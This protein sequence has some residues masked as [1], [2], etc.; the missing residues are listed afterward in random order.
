MHREYVIDWNRLRSED[1]KRTSFELLC[2]QVARL[3]KP[4]SG[5]EFIPN[6]NPDGG[7]DCYWRLKNS[8]IHAWQ[9]KFF[10]R[11]EKS[12]WDQID[13]SVKNAIKNYPKLTKYT[14]CVPLN[15]PNSSQ[16]SARQ[17]WERYKKKW[18]KLKSGVEYIFHGHDEFVNLLSNDTY[19]GKLKYFFG[20]I[21]FTQTWLNDQMD[22]LKEAI[23]LRYSEEYNIDLPIIEK[24]NALCKTNEFI[25]NMHTYSDNLDKS[26]KVVNCLS[27]NIDIDFKIYDEKIMN[28]INKLKSVNTQIEHDVKIKDLINECDLIANDLEL[29]EKRIESYDMF[30]SYEPHM[31]DNNRNNQLLHQAQNKLRNARSLL[32]QNLHRLQI[33]LEE[34]ICADTRQ[35][36]V[37]GDAG[38]G[39]T[40]LFFDVLQKRLEK[41]HPTILLLGQWF[42]NDPLD[43]IPKLLRLDCNID[44]FLGAFNSHAEATGHRALLLIDA[45]NESPNDNIWKNHLKRLSEI[46]SRYKSI[47]FAISVRSGY[48]KKYDDIIP[49]RCMCVEHKGFQ[50]NPKKYVDIFFTKNGL[51]APMMPFLRQEFSTPQFLYLL[52]RT[53][54]EKQIRNTSYDSLDI[55]S[56]YILYIK[57]INKK[58]CKSDKLD[59]DENSNIVENGINELARL[60]ISQSTLELDYD[61]AYNCLMGV[62]YSEGNSKSLLYNLIQEGILLKDDERNKIRFVYERLAE[63]LITREY[64]NEFDHSTIKKSFHNGGKLF[65]F[66]SGDNF[67]DNNSGI[68]DAILIQLPDKFGIELV[69]II[70]DVLNNPKMVIAILGSLPL[71]KSNNITTKTIESLQEIIL[72]NGN[73]DEYFKALLTL[74]IKE[75]Q[76]INANYLHRK[77]LSMEISERDLLWSTFIHRQYSNEG[78]VFNY[79]NWAQNVKYDLNSRE[80]VSLAATTMCW[81]LTS[82]HKIIRDNVI[83]A[84]IELMHN[85]AEEWLMI[86]KKFKNCNDPYV[87]ANLYAVTYAIVLTNTTSESQIEKI[88]LYVYSEIFAA[89]NPPHSIFIQDYARRI[90]NYANIVIPNLSI[91]S[92]NVE[93]PYK[94]AILKFPKINKIELLISRISE[95]GYDNC[96]VKDQGLLSLGHS[97]NEMSDFVRYTLGSNSNAFPWYNIK[98]KQGKSI[99]DDVQ[100]IFKKSP[101]LSELLY[102]YIKDLKCQK[103][104]FMYNSTKKN[105]KHDKINHR[106][107]IQKVLNA[108]DR[109][110]FNKIVEPYL[111]MKYTHAHNFIYKTNFISFIIFE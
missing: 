47:S 2:S 69:E 40:H 74:T 17:K 42:E 110:I 48:V 79:I 56:V 20:G 63:H 1:S 29:Y 51:I 102:K 64:L 53:M 82:S 94:N 54:K 57:S 21:S 22:V 72:D 99:I 24:F 73:V 11:L 107:E 86:F 88:A 49:N 52:C 91:V 43:E 32:Y 37:I 100:K 111:K 75:N 70:P 14:I 84:L 89:N 85:D 8:D 41:N 67:Y 16:N 10:Y 76:N 93:P 66:F 5:I 65:K 95:R 96:N 46:I 92:S 9:A 83:T 78:I 87:V 33:F 44:E 35:I 98:L 71:R 26:L 6:G 3:K 7:V 109:I 60:M 31:Q 27:E 68:I 34:R 58:L 62:Y 25:I 30:K 45:L 103:E 106:M 19:I 23:G 36:M 18:L 105:K 80:Q 77:L 4:P 39:K 81:F 59:Y 28:L 13:R 12:Q 61:V 101:Q 90:I 38:M 55:L 108:H 104:I 97:L 50:D 15:L